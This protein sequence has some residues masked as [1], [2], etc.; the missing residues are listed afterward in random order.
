MIGIGI[1]NAIR[2]RWE[3][4]AGSNH[5]H[6]SADRFASYDANFALLPD[7]RPDANAAQEADTAVAEPKPR[8][9]HTNV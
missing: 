3:G 5:E 7:T 8:A 6:V 1:I 9:K 2:M 4:F